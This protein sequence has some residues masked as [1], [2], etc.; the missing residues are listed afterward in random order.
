MSIIVLVLIMPI[1]IVFNGCGSSDRFQEGYNAGRESGYT[2]GFSNG[3]EEGFN[4]GMNSR[5]VAPM[6]VK[7]EISTPVPNET[8]GHIR[9]NWDLVE[10]ATHY[11]VYWVI[12]S[13]EDIIRPF[14]SFELL[15]GTEHRNSRDRHL[16]TNTLI[17]GTGF[18]IR[19][20]ST[21]EG[22][23]LGFPE[24]NWTIAINVRAHSNNENI[25]TSNFSETR[26]LM[27]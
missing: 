14:D 27:F 10:G 9:V 16:V 17:T 19:G 2:D 11:S 21:G 13:A 24:S 7:T 5:L 20:F 12:V 6:N 8:G 1:A 15:A 18:Y 22:A 25:Q 4:S 23:F 3:Y 26:L